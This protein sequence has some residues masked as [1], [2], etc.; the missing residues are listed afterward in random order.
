MVAVV[1]TG[2]PAE[3]AGLK[4]QDGVVRI[5]GKVL[6]GWPPAALVALNMAAPGVTHAYTLAGGEVQTATARDFF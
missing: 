1:S 6:G 2:R 4:A 5:S 3:A